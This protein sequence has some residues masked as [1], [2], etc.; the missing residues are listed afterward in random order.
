[1]QTQQPDRC[2]AA[3]MKLSDV[4]GLLGVSVTLWG[5]GGGGGGADGADGRPEEHALVIDAEAD[6]CLH[7][8]PLYSSATHLRFDLKNGRALRKLSGRTIFYLFVY[9]CV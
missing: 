3:L 1:M 9:V 4:T 6:C 5:G 2:A 7:K 8:A